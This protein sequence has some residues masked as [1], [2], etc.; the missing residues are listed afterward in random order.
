MEKYVIDLR[1]GKR[2]NT[3][4]YKAKNDIASVLEKN[5][6]RCLP[7]YFYNAK[8]QKVLSVIKLIH[9]INEIKSG[10]LIYQFPLG[11]KKVDKLIL[12]RLRTH[13][14]I[15]KIAII[16]DIESLRNFNDNKDFRNVEIKQL[17]S[18]DGLIVH[19]LKMKKWLKDA[20]IL[21]PMISLE[22]FDYLDSKI[23]D[24]KVSDNIIFAGN[25]NKAQFLKKLKINSKI[26]IFGP[27]R[28]KVYPKN[29]NYIGMYLPDE[30]INHIQGSFGLIWDGASINGCNGVYGNYEKYN[31]P[32]K[33]SLY[34]STGMPVIVWKKAAISDFV[35]KNNIGIS[36]DSLKD[37]DTI[38][39]DLDNSKYLK[40]KENAEKVGQKIRM[41]YYTT[42]S[43]KKMIAQLTKTKGN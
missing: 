4:Q 13:N 35:K 10:I 17:N 33:L 9:Q 30:L 8:I 39:S 5:G 29:I 11:S 43:V 19:T 14:N 23:I 34:L 40:L 1:T 28:S 2:N 18:F 37:L 7:Y 25:L 16:H 42:Q 22:V 12:S 41:G 24:H 20:G 3:A 26:N 38:L 21:K 6:Y 15:K 27:N 36:V 32:H 31:S